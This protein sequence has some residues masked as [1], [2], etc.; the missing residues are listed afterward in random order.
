MISEVRESARLHLSFGSLL[1]EWRRLKRRSQLDLATEIGTTTRHL[2][3]LET[4]RSNPSRT[5]IV[6]LAT[7]LDIPLREQ[8]MLFRAAGF[9]DA[10]RESGF[11][12][13]QMRAV[14]DVVDRLLTSHEPF[15]AFAF[16]RH[17][18]LVKTNSAV[19]RLLGGLVDFQAFAEQGAVS[20]LDL[21]FHPDGLRPHIVNWHETGHHM[22]QRIHREAL[23]DREA[24][25]V[26]KRIMRYPDMPEDWQRLDVGS[27]LQPVLPLVLR[28]QEM[29]L[30]FISMV[31][32]FGTPQD[33]TVEELRIELMFPADGGTDKVIR[34]LNV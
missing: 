14:R 20:V 9:A 29:D 22:I 8:N 4:G 30:S 28:Y 19:L 3:F 2:S 34:N 7:A 27:P 31:T 6:R 21:V 26:L 10:Y 17:W 13:D 33:V 16:D 11:S 5:M 18:T 12:D 15:P 25:R 32:T 24:A 23:D 1:R